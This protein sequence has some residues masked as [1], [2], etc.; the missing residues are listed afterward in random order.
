MR[1]GSYIDVFVTLLEP[2][3]QA[4]DYFSFFACSDLPLIR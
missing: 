2:Y 4:Q 1:T 3:G